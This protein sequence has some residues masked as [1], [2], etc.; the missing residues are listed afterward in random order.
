MALAEKHGTKLSVRLEQIT[1]LTIVVCLDQVLTAK[2]AAEAG[3]NTPCDP[4]LISNV[5]KQKLV[6]L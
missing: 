5:S 3:Q 2:A 6:T 1:S 4:S